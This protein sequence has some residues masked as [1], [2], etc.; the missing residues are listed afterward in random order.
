MKFIEYTILQEIQS[1]LAERFGKTISQGDNHLPNVSNYITRG[2]NYEKIVTAQLG[3]GWRKIPCLLSLG[4]LACLWSTMRCN[5]NLDTHSYISVWRKGRIE[6]W[7]LLAFFT[8]PSRVNPIFLAFIAYFWA[9]I[10]GVMSRI[11][12]VDNLDLIT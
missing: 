6:A 3:G 2:N 11:V 8:C 1:R 10:L 7:L 4:Y 12:K 9:R 5:T